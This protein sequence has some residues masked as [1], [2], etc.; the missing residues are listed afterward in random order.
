MEVLL[1]QVSAYFQIMPF[2]DPTPCGGF[3][4][5]NNQSWPRRCRPQGFGGGFRGLAFVSCAGP[6][7]GM[8]CSFDDGTRFVAG[9]SA[10]PLLQYYDAIQVIDDYE[11]IHDRAAYVN[12]PMT[13]QEGHLTSDALPGTNLQDFELSAGTHH[14]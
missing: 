13:D 6:F 3:G 8:E 1:D 14:Q 10:T 12:S 4:N 9:L 5:D 11:V 7:R 2:S